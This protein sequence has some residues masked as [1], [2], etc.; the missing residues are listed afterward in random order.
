MRKLL[1]CDA[2]SDGRGTGFLPKPRILRK[3]R[4]NPVPSSCL[5]SAPSSL[6]TKALDSSSPVVLSRIGVRIDLAV[7]T[8]DRIDV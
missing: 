2:R 4:A 7:K 5:S 8:V 3:G 6:L 1:M